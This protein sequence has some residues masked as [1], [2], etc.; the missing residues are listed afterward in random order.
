[1]RSSFAN[2]IK[3]LKSRLTGK[4]R[5]RLTWAVRT[6]RKA[7]L[8]VEHLEDR[9]VPATYAESLS[10]GF[11]S[12]TQAGAGNDNLMLALSN[13][14]YILTDIGGSF[15]TP[16]GNESG[17]ISLPIQNSIYIHPSTD[18]SSI[19]IILGSGTN[20]FTL[21]GT[22]SSAAPL[23]VNTGSNAG[24]QLNITGSVSDSGTVSLNAATITVQSGVQVIANTISLTSVNSLQLQTTGIP[25]LGNVTINAAPPAGQPY[26]NDPYVT[27][28]DWGVY[29]YQPGD[30]VTISDRAP[31]FA[32]TEV[33]ANTAIS[34]IG[35]AVSALGTPSDQISSFQGTAPTINF[36]DGESS[37]DFPSPTPQP[38]P[39]LGLNSGD[40][41]N[42]S[43]E[44]T[45]VVIHATAEVYIPSAGTWT[46]GTNSDDGTRLEVANNT[47]LE[48][49]TTNSPADTFG[50][51]NFTAPGLYPLDLVYFNH[52]G[53]GEVALFASPGNFSSFTDPGASFALVGD[54]VD[55]GLSVTTVGSPSG[56]QVANV[57]GDNLYLDNSSSNPLPPGNYS[58]VV[59]AITSGTFT[60][61]LTANSVSLNVTGS[62]NSISGAVQAG[63]LAATTGNGNITLN[64]LESVRLN[65]IDA[66]SADIA[67]D[68]QGSMASGS[69][70]A[71]GTVNLEGASVDLTTTGLGNSIGSAGAFLSTDI[72]DLTATTNDGGVYISNG[73]SALTIDSVEADQDGQSPFVDDDQILYNSTPAQPSPTYLPGSSNV[74]II[75]LGPVTL[76]SISATGSATIRGAYIVEGNDQ[77][78]TVIAR[79]MTLRATGAANY[80][81]QVTFANSSAGDTLTLP[82]GEDWSSY[83]FSNG[84]T[85]AGDAMVVSGA[86]TLS[87]DST[88]TIASISGNVLTLQQSYSVTPETD[89]LVT[90]GDGMIG[91]ESSSPSSTTSSASTSQEAI[92]LSTVGSFTATTTNGNIDLTLGGSVDSTA[93]NVDAG[94]TGDVS[95]TSQSNFLT[96]ENISATG[97][98]IGGDVMGGSVVV[99]MN[100]GSLFEYPSSGSPD[101]GIVSG[102]YVSLMSPLNIGT[103][104]TPFLTNASSGLNVTANATSPSEAAVYIVNTS[105][106]TSLGVSTYDGT[107]E[108][109][110]TSNTSTPL[111]S[112]NDNQLNA[113]GSAVVSFAN[114]DDSDGSADNVVVNGTIDANSITAGGQIL[115]GSNTKIT[116]Q[117]L[118]LSA[119]NGVGVPGSSI[120][121]AVI[122]LDAS[123]NTGNIEI[124][125]MAPSTAGSGATVN[126]TTD[127][128]AMTSVTLPS[129]GGG[130]G[131]PANSTIELMVTGGGGSGAVIEAATN[132]SGTIASVALLTGGGGYANTTGA[133]T[134]AAFMLL[135]ASTSNGNI[136]VVSTGGSDLILDG[137][138][139]GSRGTATFTSDAAID[140][141]TSAS[142]TA[143]SQSSASAVQSGLATGTLTL[144]ATT[145]IGTAGNPLKTSATKLTASGGALFLSNNNSLTLAT[146][147]T[148]ITGDV[149]V[150]TIGDLVLSSA[151]LGTT[152]SDVSLTATAGSLTQTGGSISAGTLTLSAEQIGDSAAYSPDG[153]ASEAND[154]IQTDATTILATADY[155]G[156]YLSNSATTALT[157]TADAVGPTPNDTATNNIGISTDGTI[158]LVPQT[159]TL[160]G[161]GATPI[162]LYAPGG[163]VTLVAG[164]NG[165]VAST[166]DIVSGLGSTSS[167]TA[168]MAVSGTGIP[169]GD[170]VQDILNS[171]EIVLSEPATASGTDVKLTVTPVITA[172][173]N[174]SGSTVT[175]LGSTTSSLAVGMP[176]SGTGIPAGDTIR[177]VNGGGQIALSEPATFNGTGITLT[178]LATS[179]ST[180]AT[181]NTDG[182]TDT[183]Y[184]VYTGTL[185]IGNSTI[186]NSG[187]LSGSGYG[188]LATETNTAEVAVFAPI[189]IANAGP[190]QLTASM[191]A[192]GGTYDGSSITIG[193][194]GPTPLAI[195]GN[196]TLESTGAI[197]FLDPNNS[198]SLGG[199]Y[200]LT[201]EAGSVAALG[202]ITTDH[203][204]ITIVAAG[205]VGI[206]TVNAGSGTVTIASSGSIFN[207]SGGTLSVSGGQTNL[208]QAQIQVY[209]QGQSPTTTQ[210]TTNL[211]QLELQA[212]AALATAAAASAQAAA[213]QT[214]ANALQ[215]ELNSIQ[216]A[217]ANASETYQTDLQAEN[218]ADNALNADQNQVNYDTEVA[219]GL[220]LASA[221]TGEL[222]A[223]TSLGGDLLQLGGDAALAIQLVGNEVAAP[224]YIVADTVATIADLENFVSATANLASASENIT[225]YNDTLTLNNAA[226]TD[227]TAHDSVDQSYAQW[228]ADLDSA[229][230][231]AAAYDVAE[232][233]YSSEAITA[234]QDQAVAQADS[235][236]VQAAASAQSGSSSGSQS[237]S[238]QSTATTDPLTV[239]G[240]PLTI[241]GEAPSGSTVTNL[242]VSAPITLG[243][244]ISGISANGTNWTV[245]TTAASGLAQGQSV[246]ISGVTPAAYD[247]T[248]TVTGTAT[249]SAPYTFT[250]ASTANPGPAGSGGTAAAI[251]AGITLDGNGSAMT[252][253][254]NITAPGSIDLNEPA[255]AAGGDNLSVTPGASVASE[256]SSVS[257]AAGDNLEISAGATIQASST[258]SIT[259]D[260]NDGTYQGQVVFTS[261]TL[262]LPTNGTSWTSLG[263][264]P[265]GSMT[266]SGA[267]A[268]ADN[269]TFTIAPGGISSNGYTLT[270]TVSSLAPETDAAVTVEATTGASDAGNVAAANVTVAGT[271]TAKSALIN[272]PSASTRS[273]TFTIAPSTTTPITVAGSGQATDTLNIDFDTAGQA[274]TISETQTK[275]GVQTLESGTIAATGFAPVAFSNF[276]AVTIADAAGGA[277]LTL[278]GN[279][280]IA[281]IMTLVGSA[282][283]AGTVT[284]NNAPLSFSDVANFTYNGGIG[285][286]IGV[287]PFATTLLPWNLAVTISGGSGSP[288]S[289]TYNAAGPADTV[290]ATGPNAGSVAEPGVAKI[291]L[292]NVSKVAVA[293]QGIQNVQL[294]PNLTVSDA[295][296]IYNGKAFTAQ[297]QLNG[298][299]SLGGVT[300]THT[301]YNGNILTPAEELSGAPINAGTYTVV[302]A[303]AGNTTYASASAS[304]TFTIAPGTPHVSVNPV[305]LTDG[306]A[307]ANSQLSGTATFRVDGTNVTVPGIYSYTSAAGTVLTPSASAY[308]EQVTFKPNNTID[309]V[310]QTNLS[311]LVTVPALVLATATAAGPTTKVRV[312]YSNGTSDTWDPFGSKCKAGATVAVGDVTGDGYP[313]IIVA[314]GGGSSAGTVQVYSG[315]T[316]TLIASYKPLGSFRGGLDVAVGNV[317]GSGPDDIVVGVMNGGY[318]LVTVLDGATGK[319]IDQFLAYAKSF[320]GGVRV[321]VGNINGTGEADVVVGPGAGQHGLPV[322]VY[323][324]QSIMTGTATPQLLASF[325]PFASSYTGAVDVA[326][327]NLTSTSYADLVVGTQSSGE[328][329]K[330]YSGEGLSLSSPP[331]P[332]FT[333]NA[334]ATKDNSGVKLALV[335]DTA[336]N[337]LDDL[338]ETNGTGSKTA[339]YL[340]ADLTADGWPTSDAEFF[341]A[342]PGV[343]TG[344][345]VG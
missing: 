131:Y 30:T 323:S 267:F 46:F 281:N 146:S 105:D 68:A 231:V 225:L 116:G 286:T 139:T 201:I 161:A 218:Q 215:A 339:R 92:S 217:V 132:S 172:T 320:R 232:Q 38:M 314:S 253:S 106:P 121:T 26:A 40:D 125:Q 236:L 247:G 52:N 134:S 198:I 283:G 13:S 333:Q 120:N 136:N 312:T 144:A 99:G 81:G 229:T 35:D 310:T 135:G 142:G 127:D 277:T 241:T 22:D 276:A 258:I 294:L 93:V 213:E 259:G 158:V 155:G 278:N 96:I 14:T 272:V 148:G 316:R 202:N 226:N 318:P 264:A 49:D 187:T 336:G 190:L 200:S 62:Q 110:Q 33:T 37:P 72:A 297:V 56:Y 271:L 130:S 44:V 280:S 83:G 332:L 124:D 203:G 224:I 207:I 118:L 73:A 245:T 233:A 165:Y 88:F 239:N 186:T 334:W 195:N 87:N 171:S 289:L 69:P 262:T 9:V 48:D 95:V 12:I 74:S 55:G 341:R 43:D 268:A 75:S 257:L 66:G 345:Y 19:S 181:G 321:G 31:N 343:T 214:T 36:E 151:T 327:G 222:S 42:E 191:L 85:M 322:E 299:A 163:T 330:V 5:D 250:I 309:Y 288:A 1:M 291:L 27:G 160:P 329:I 16:T 169:A 308:S 311:V 18:V 150:S 152:S 211:A 273:T 168:G 205:N 248:W 340:N 317:A 90:V 252:V 196:L 265:G 97:N 84:T 51:Y 7:G 199:G 86:T 175:G 243:N 17:D 174:I 301:Y 122:A 325:T 67:L 45:N 50:T 255:E 102:Q 220:N 57:V 71:P 112:F 295:S 79:K 292:E 223:V 235:A 212:A 8:G 188:P 313:D 20:V 185:I 183:Y 23:T 149:T 227:Q 147:G 166:Y 114:T 76:N 6:I 304:T 331:T 192:N 78:P 328:Q 21:S 24:D 290:T 197:V 11:L 117:S 80:Q 307:L 193:E 209:G 261:N 133:G 157:L 282:Q 298:K 115:A 173:G 58:D 25:F 61:Q 300:P 54:T 77:S 156:I 274:V 338:I 293:Y 63:N 65:T 219:N 128:G 194:L 279:S 306:I 335:P 303:F 238:P 107:V 269:G 137:I 39:G 326:V 104:S 4:R 251:P 70:V 208:A 305:T 210:S 119:G 177:Q 319:V 32:I 103:L 170:T 216:T 98:T 162:A 111:L 153:S 237:S 179:Q 143:A 296:G 266:I 275:V 240:G 206:G 94:G 100:S 180:T 154:V 342:I 82:A 10:N 230:A 167:L 53:P 184:D 287:T 228:Q 60:P 254:A 141:T 47:V 3:N 242:T 189:A 176:V 182:S 59:V 34:S 41:T 145:G 244:S 302:A 221:I 344:V 123:T 29:G 315:A 256:N 108:I 140:N 15:G 249:T 28:P 109:D 234:E 285:D 246:T 101:P 89:P 113:T 204:A 159:T 178:F 263:F 64:D 91:L 260:T 324:G 270:L 138:S 337:G 284:L 126:I 129:G 2:W 164:A